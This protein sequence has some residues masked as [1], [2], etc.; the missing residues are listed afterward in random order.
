MTGSTLDEIDEG[1]LHL[2]QQD[3]RNHPPSDMAERLPVSEGTVRNPI[4]KMEE[5]GVIKGYT[6]VID[7]EQAGYTVLVAF[8]CPVAISER[9]ELARDAADIPGVIEVEEM[10]TGPPHIR[11][12][13]ITTSSEGITDIAVAWTDRGLDVERGELVNGIYV[14][15]FDKIGSRIVNDPD[16]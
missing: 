1:I 11:V 4:A 14:Q 13:A 5:R 3:A 2:L 15:P 7:Y 9:A 16:E 12:N 6:S 10:M 8:S